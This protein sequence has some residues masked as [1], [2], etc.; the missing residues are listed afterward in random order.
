[1]ER[2]FYNVKP[3]FRTSP[4]LRALWFRWL[5]AAILIL[6]LGQFFAVIFSTGHL[7]MLALS[8][9][10]LVAVNLLHRRRR[11]TKDQTDRVMRPTKIPEPSA[12]AAR[13]MNALDTKT[14]LNS[15]T[16][17]QH[18]IQLQEQPTPVVEVQHGDHVAPRPSNSRPL[19]AKP[20]REIFWPIPVGIFFAI[21]GVVVAHKAIDELARLES[22]WLEDYNPH[23]R[24]AASLVIVLFAL[25]CIHAVRKKHRSHR[26]TADE[27]SVPI[28]TQ[29]YE[30]GGR[31][32]SLIRMSDADLT[33]R[34]HLLIIN[35]QG[36]PEK[37]DDIVVSA[38]R[39]HGGRLVL[40]DAGLVL[41]WI[42]L[43]VL[44]AWASGKSTG[45]YDLPNTWLMGLASGFALMV[46]FF[47]QCV[48]WRAWC[49]I[50]T[51]KRSI[52]SVQ[53]P[54]YLFFLKDRRLPVADPEVSKCHARDQEPA[55][56]HAFRTPYGI[57]DLDGLSDDDNIMR[58]M[59]TVPEYETLAEV[60]NS[61]RVY[62]GK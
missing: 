11:R 8:I 58:N 57:L 59:R 19:H 40:I 32:F 22:A 9:G 29:Y 60:I 51:N 2:F 56:S 35:R 34:M 37:S 20:F 27:L 55:I 25:Y 62:A 5:I 23:T 31:V 44:Y 16:Q 14:A 26:A 10:L 46:L 36:E 54:P 17:P 6:G 21:V 38:T 49:F 30:K 13:G 53:W 61:A 45:T 48:I 12:T 28:S 7:L 50:R 52:V 43:V 24:V 1:M 4:L 18:R 15:V 42:A 33:E 39:K 41:C 3:C 47:V